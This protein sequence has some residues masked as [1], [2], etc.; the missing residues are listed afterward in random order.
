MALVAPRLKPPRKAKRFA[1]IWHL[2]DIPDYHPVTLVLLRYNVGF[3][4][5]QCRECEAKIMVSEVAGRFVA[6]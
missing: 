3:W 6:L 5:F 4:E 1:A 2:L